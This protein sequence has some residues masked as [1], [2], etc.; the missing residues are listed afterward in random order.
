MLLCDSWRGPP[1]P[2]DHQLVVR[3]QCLSTI[4]MSTQESMKAVHS[5]DHRYTAAQR[6]C[7]TEE[8]WNWFGSEEY[9]CEFDVC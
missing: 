3:K 6:N 1:S 8:G 5:A 2:E 9:V 4:C 7:A